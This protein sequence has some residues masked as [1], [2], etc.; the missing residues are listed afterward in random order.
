VGYGGSCFPKDTRALIQTGREYTTPMRI[1]EAVEAVNN[2]QAHRFVNRVIDHFK[3]K[4]KDKRF[5]VWGLSFKPRT[6]DMRDA[7]AIRI[8]EQLLGK[9]AAI[10]AYD[11]EAMDEGKRIFGSRIEF[12]A[13]NYDCLTGADALLLVTEWQEFRNPN[14]ERIKSSM[15]SPVIFDGRNIFESGHIRNLGFTYYSIGRK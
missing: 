3:G 15:R 9:G 10:S 14:F 8:I 5:G 7:P 12:A 1:L 6:N 4:L 13:N 11:P 2:D